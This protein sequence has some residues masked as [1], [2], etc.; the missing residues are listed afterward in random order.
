LEYETKYTA[1]VNY[2][3]LID[4]YQQVI[5]KRALTRESL[6][7]RIPAAEEVPPA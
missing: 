2:R 4:I 1:A 7:M 3:Q 6:G 5:A